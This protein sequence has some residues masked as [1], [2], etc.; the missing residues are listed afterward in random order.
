M[1]AAECQANALER[2][3]AD[4]A[5]RR[6]GMK[7]H[8]VDI[9][10]GALMTFP[11]AEFC[12]QMRYGQNADTAAASALDSYRYLVLECTKEEAWKRIKLIR[13]AAINAH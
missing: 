1:C 12:N 2:T 4:E 9:G 7:V 10:D 5:G 6:M 11:V 8:F 3:A 13:S